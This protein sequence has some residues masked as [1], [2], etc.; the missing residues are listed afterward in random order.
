[1]DEGLEDGWRSTTPDDDTVLRRLT[2]A[3][4]ER[5]TFAAER[6]GGRVVRRDD[7][8]LGD[9]GSAVIFDNNV[10]LT[11]APERADLPAVIAVARELYG[12]RAWLLVSALP[13]PDLSAHGLRLMGHPP[14]MLRAPGG[15]AP[16]VPGGLRLVEVDDAQT[17]AHWADTLAT[18]YPTPGGATPPLDERVL[19]GPLRLWIGYEVDRPVATSA[20]FVRHGIVEVDYISTMPDARRR[21]YGAAVTWA[22]TLADPSLPAALV[23]S[24]EGRPLYESMGYL[25]VTRLT[26]WFEGQGWDD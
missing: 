21:G 10:V 2:L 23:A 25:P 7:A 3:F 26:I 16:A 20:A 8:L 22:A 24:D 19:G 1:M 6:L 17:L 11:V 5:T 18:A 4:G 13:L 14:L 9:F 15:E 12:D